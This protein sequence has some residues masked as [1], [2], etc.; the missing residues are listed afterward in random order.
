M[1]YAGR[2]LGHLGNYGVLRRAIAYQ[3]RGTQLKY[4][5]PL[6]HR[7]GALAGMAWLPP[8]EDPAN[9]LRRFARS[10]P[11]PVLKKA[12]AEAVVTYY[13]LKS[14]ETNQE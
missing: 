12:C 2:G 14:A 5:Y 11:E 8:E 13:R 7:L 10:L 1:R 6:D 3:R 9:R 4:I